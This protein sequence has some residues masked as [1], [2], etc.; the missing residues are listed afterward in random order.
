MFDNADIADIDLS[1]FWPPSS[2]GSVI[3]TTQRRDFSHWA[4]N[5]IHLDTFN[6]DDGARLV[7]DV[8]DQSTETHSP[9]TV[10]MARE[11]SSELG[12]LPLLLSHISGYIEGT[13]APLASILENLKQ[14]AVFNRIWAF[15]S[16][17]STNFQYREPMAKVWRLALNSLNPE[18]LRTLQIMAM[19]S[20]DEVYED[21]L[22]GEWE[23]AELGFL[24]ESK[25]F[26]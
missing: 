3:I 12:G 24:A 8:V 14:P 19:L 20:P 15:D 23:D 16:T 18:A 10:K 25:R 7:L 9:E 17:T 11:I 21:M 5:D 13:Q 26:E 22:F 1:Q 6:E 4:A 2:H